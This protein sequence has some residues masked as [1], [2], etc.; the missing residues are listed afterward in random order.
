M[1]V[2]FKSLKSLS[3]K[4]VDVGYEGIEHLLSNCRLLE[5]VV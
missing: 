2:R 1:F 3:L 4:A 5:S